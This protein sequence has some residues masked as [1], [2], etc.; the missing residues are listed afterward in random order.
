MYVKN[1][2]SQ[3]VCILIFCLFETTNWK[4]VNPDGGKITADRLTF[5]FFYE[6]YLSGVKRKRPPFVSPSRK[7]LFFLFIYFFGSLQ[8]FLTNR[9]RRRTVMTANY[10]KLFSFIF[11]SN[12]ISIT[13]ASLFSFYLKKA[14]V[15]IKIIVGWRKR[16]SHKKWYAYT[17]FFTETFDLFFLIY[18]HMYLYVCIYAIYGNNYYYNDDNT[19]G[20]CYNAPYL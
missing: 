9:R 5:E 17:I 11:F 4:G 3:N 12:T 10:C 8:F 20:W 15:K 2:F 1:T 18:I 6:K 13:Q 7:F 14:A 16:E 19:S